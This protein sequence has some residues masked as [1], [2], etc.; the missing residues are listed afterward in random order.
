[1]S[2]SLADIRKEYGD[3]EPFII[4]DDDKERALVLYVRSSLSPSKIAKRLKE[5]GGNDLGTVTI[6][7]WVNQGGWVKLRKQY[8]ETYTSKFTEKVAENQ[9]DAD[10]NSQQ[11]VR[12][13]YAKISGELMNMVHQKLKFSKPK[14][15]DAALLSPLDIMQLSIAMKT[16]ADVHFRALGM[17]EVSVIDPTVGQT[18]IQILTKQD[19]E[20]LGLPPPK[21]EE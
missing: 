21:D 2:R 18:G 12:E 13:V 20:R 3:N 17:P 11:V 6:K 8:K 4:G 10:A 5:W 9:A 14:F 7:N 15:A 1:M 16:S 19:Q